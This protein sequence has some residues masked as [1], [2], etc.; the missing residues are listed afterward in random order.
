MIF[1]PMENFG[2]P[3]MLARADLILIY[4]AMY[5]HMSDNSQGTARNGATETSLLCRALKTSECLMHTCNERVLYSL[6]AQNCESR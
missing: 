5:M 2:V 6:A 1:A 4:V 3:A